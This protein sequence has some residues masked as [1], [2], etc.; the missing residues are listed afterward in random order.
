MEHNTMGVDSNMWIMDSGSTLHMRLSKTGI[1]NLVQWKAPITLGNRQHIFSELK[2]IF[3]GQVFY[4]KGILLS[5]TMDDVLY[6]SE[7]MMNLFSL[8]KTLQ[9]IQI[10]FERIGKYLAIIINGNKL[11]GSLGWIR[12]SSWSR[13]FYYCK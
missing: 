10:G 5:V 12:C 11:E 8:T 4:E 9:N 1:A 3:K 7:L 6:V 13:Y 2:G